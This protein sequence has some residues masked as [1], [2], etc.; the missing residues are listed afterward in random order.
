MRPDPGLRES[1]CACVA[2]CCSLL[3]RSP[4]QGQGSGLLGHSQRIGDES[5]VALTLTRLL[6]S[7]LLPPSSLPSAPCRSYDAVLAIDPSHWRSLLNKAVVQTCTGDKNEAAFNLKL[8]LKLSGQGSALQ[9]EIDQLKKMLK[10]GANWDV[11][12]QMMSY[13]S[14]KAAQVGGV[15][16]PALR[17][18]APHH[19]PSMIV[20]PCVT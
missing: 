18:S 16:G 11:I 6:S 10:Q 19:S 7:F 17:G 4:Q 12:S 15:G 1:D 3:L 13:I 2:P 20:L 8:A 9:Q 5:R 14:D